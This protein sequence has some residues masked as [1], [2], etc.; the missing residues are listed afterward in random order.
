[1]SSHSCA[2]SILLGP[3]TELSSS[4]ISREVRYLGICMWQVLRTKANWIGS[5]LASVRTGL[6]RYVYSPYNHRADLKV[7]LLNVCFPAPRKELAEVVC[8]GL[9]R[10]PSTPSRTISNF[11]VC[12]RRRPTILPLPE[13]RFNGETTVS[14]FAWFFGN[15]NHHL[16]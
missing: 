7:R 6:V 9:S 8:T 1:M 3:P 12:A 15:K 10:T 13:L 16:L 2:N 4:V 14:A 11:T 5:T